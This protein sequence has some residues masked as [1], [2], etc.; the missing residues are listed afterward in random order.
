MLHSAR[1]ICRREICLRI[2]PVYCI[3]YPVMIL[4]NF[5]VNSWSSFLT[6]ADCKTCHSMNF[7][8]ICLCISTNLRIKIYCKQFNIKVREFIDLFNFNLQA[9]LV[10]RQNL[11]DK[12]RVVPFRNRSKYV[13]NGTN[14]P[15]L[16][17]T[18]Q[19]KSHREFQGH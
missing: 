17:H 7:K 18:I 11:L 2:D 19:N 14:L 13:L 15:N 6:T 5:S 9:Y 12:N 1:T 3:D 4:I 8:H 16:Q 10:D